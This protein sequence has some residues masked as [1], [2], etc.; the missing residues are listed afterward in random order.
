MGTSAR[1]NSCNGSGSAPD[2][3]GRTPVSISLT[4][5]ACPSSSP[6][7]IRTDQL[8]PGARAQAWR[9]WRQWLPRTF[10]A[11]V[12]PQGN[13]GAAPMLQLQVR[14]LMVPA[15]RHTVL[16]RLWRTARAAC[17][18]PCLCE[19]GARCH[20]HAA[21][22]AK[23]RYAPLERAKPPRLRRKARQLLVKWSVMLCPS[24]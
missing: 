4:H 24:R 14:L 18:L 19:A 9:I 23:D 8:T 22:A 5:N 17:G 6:C 3:R 10:E 21:A 12:P 11:Y 1:P 7:A 13:G 15:G 2:H 20:R 16:A